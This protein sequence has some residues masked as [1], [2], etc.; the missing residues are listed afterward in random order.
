MDKLFKEPKMTGLACESYRGIVGQSPRMRSI[1]DFAERIKDSR[2]T[3]LICGASGTGKRLV[4]KAIH[5]SGKKGGKEKFVETSCGAL[6]REIIES[7]LFGHIK[8]AFT[9][10]IGDRKGR[11]ELADKGTILLDDIDALPL[12]LQVKLLRV[13]QQKEFE[14]VGDHNTIKVDARVIATTNGDLEALVAE[15]KFREDLFY[16]LNV[17][18]VEMPSLKDRKEDIPGLVSHFIK[19]H[20]GENDKEIKGVSEDAL[21]ILVEYNWP[22]NVRQ[23]E[24][25]I[26]RAV[27]LDTDGTITEED[28][29]SV[30]AGREIKT[31]ITPGY[32]VSGDMNVLK[33]F[34]KYPEKGHILSVLKEVEWNK[35]RAAKVLGVNRTTLYKKLQKHNI[36]NEKSCG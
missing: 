25:I 10:A 14:R 28:L 29:P 26:E 19:L 36:I 20:A 21:E 32:E 11:F 1:F 3:V 35:K 18:V 12:D 34:L 31:V 4:A 22:G 27:I 6:P 15:K 5:Q 7:E 23:L 30:L 8:G 16:R 9:G 33:D 2:A 17:L 24:N 13:L